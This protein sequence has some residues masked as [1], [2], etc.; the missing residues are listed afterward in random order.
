MADNNEL[1]E[2]SK[3]IIELEAILKRELG[4]LKAYDTFYS[5]VSRIVTLRTQA[6]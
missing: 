1:A 2:L 6:N 4:L 3:E 5:T